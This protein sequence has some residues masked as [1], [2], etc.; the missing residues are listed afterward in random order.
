MGDGGGVLALGAE[1][2]TGV[3]LIEGAVEAG[4]PAGLL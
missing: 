1:G 4:T 2:V 3:G